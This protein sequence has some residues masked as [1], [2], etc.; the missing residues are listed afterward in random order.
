MGLPSKDELKS[1][2]ETVLEKVGEACKRV[3]RD[4]SEVTIIAVSKTK[5]LSL[6]EDAIDVGMDTFGENKP[7]EIRDKTASVSRNVHWHMIGK[8]QTN[9]IKYI[10][11]TCDLIHSVDSL[12]LLE[13]LEE[14][15]IKRQLHV[16]ILLQVNVSGEETKSGFS[17][18]EVYDLLPIISKFNHLHVKGLMTIPPFVNNPEDNR[19]YFRRLKEIF[20][21][22]KSKNIDNISMNALSMG[23][24]GDYLV[25]VEE[26]ATFIRV[27]TGIFG[28]RNYTK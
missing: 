1:N 27:G 19:H 11:E 16:D 15:A 14:E 5:P 4:P 17:V 13:K 9:K 26:G 8:L 25:A 7:Q 28:E 18:D 23:M 24:T 12:K 10:I 2:Y 20:V 22:I 3:G 21:D 6:I